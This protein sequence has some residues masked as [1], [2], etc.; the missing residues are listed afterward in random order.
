MYAALQMQRTVIQLL[1]P[2]RTG[3]LWTVVLLS[4][5]FLADARWLTVG[6]LALVCVVGSVGLMI[7][8]GF[9][10]QISLG[11]AAF[12]AL[13]LVQGP[14]IA[15]MAVLQNSIM[16]VAASPAASERPLA[17]M[18]IRLGQ[19]A[20]NAKLNTHTERVLCLCPG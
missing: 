9:A 2:K 17:Q 5:P 6:N 16:P 10:G 1:P 7:L 3:W 8:T 18:I 15:A 19:Q 4:Y 14:Y 20:A 13:G 11:H 12:L